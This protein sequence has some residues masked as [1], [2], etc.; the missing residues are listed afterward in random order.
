M[1]ESALHA[2]VVRVKIEGTFAHVR[3]NPPV[4]QSYGALVTQAIDPA[5]VPRSNCLITVG[6]TRNG[7]SAPAHLRAS[8]YIPSLYRGRD[9][10]HHTP[11]AQ[12]RT[13]GIPAYGSH[14]GCLTAKRWSGQGCVIRGFGSHRFCSTVIRCHVT[15]PFWPRQHNARRQM[16]V[17]L[18]RKS[19]SAAEFVG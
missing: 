6:Q 15:F 11:P 18:K 12:I 13:G 5:G 2:D 7:S 9:A 17:T 1:V 10:C 4:R 3:I 8:A 16:L 14:L 19:P